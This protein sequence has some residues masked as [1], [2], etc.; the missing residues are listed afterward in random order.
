MTRFA[1]L[2]PRGTYVERA[3]TALLRGVEAA[4][5]TV[6]SMQAFDRSDGS[7]T[8]AVKK[9]PQD[10][11]YDAVLIADSGRVAIKAAPLIRT[12][13]GEKARILGTELWNKES[14]LAGGP[15]IGRVVEAG[16]GKECVS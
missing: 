5:G 9:L 1:S 15:A 11:S 6:V 12:N 7:I 8:A 13:V 3:S 10:S 4:G 16:V 14:S 2:V